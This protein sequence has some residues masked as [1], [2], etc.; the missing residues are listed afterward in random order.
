M[1]S[2][3]LSRVQFPR[4]SR[5]P[6]TAQ[7]TACVCSLT[8]QRSHLPPQ[9]LFRGSAHTPA[10]NVYIN[11]PVPRFSFSLPSLPLQLL[12]FAQCTSSTHTVT[13]TS[14]LQVLTY[15]SDTESQ[16]GCHC[17]HCCRRGALRFCCGSRYVRVCFC[18]CLRP[19]RSRWHTLGDTLWLMSPVARCLTHIH[20]YLHTDW[21]L[22]K[23]RTA[24]RASRSVPL[25][26]ALARPLSTAA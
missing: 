4:Q 2:Q 17:F 25:L 12:D 11:L 15:K 6:A 21:L 8:Y 19:G 22:Q 10:P 3:Y 24:H 9:K 16:D 13:S 14:T 1:P 18:C 7:Q 23:P 26:A 5:H 20:A